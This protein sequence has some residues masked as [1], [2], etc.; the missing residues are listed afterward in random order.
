[1]T[2]WK[3]LHDNPRLQ[4]MY[5]T[6]LSILRLIR[7]FFWAQNFVET[8]TPIAL[9]L[10]GQEPYLNP[11]AVTFFDPLGRQEQ[12][13]LQTSPEFAMKKLLAAG[14][15]NI[16]QLAKCFRNGE[17]FGDGTHN[18]EF[19]M[20]EWYRAPGTLPQIMDDLEALFK[21]V[22]EKLGVGTVK[23]GVYEVSI[24]NPWQRSTMK[25]LWQEYIGINLDD[26]LELGP[27]RQLAAER[28]HATSEADEYE[29]LFFKIFLNEIEPHL[30][31]ERP[32]FVYDY[33]ARM[34]SLSR[35]CDHDPRYAERVEVYIG[36]LELANGFGELTESHEQLRRLEQD[37]ALR[38]KLGKATWA[39]DADFIG[40]LPAI[41]PPAGGI[42][43]GVDRM[44]LLFTGARTL[45]EVVFQTVSDQ[46][47]C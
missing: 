34:C 2:V 9:K 40:A 23:Y 1:M 36:G 19:T 6:R 31:V 27:L 21:Y 43:L 22:G 13:Y 4:T 38:H 10:P 32:I 33:P 47:N 39:V 30:G 12:F 46:I 18:T 44:V 8:D 20:L 37:Q 41:P 14:F 3:E 7:E 25:Q 42:A 28:G 45:E 29:D 26:Y 15:Q 16:F 17:A 11:A 35:R 5:R 24:V